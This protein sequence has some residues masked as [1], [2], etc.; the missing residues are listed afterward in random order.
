MALRLSFCIVAALLIAGCTRQ[1]VDPKPQNAPAFVAWT[2]EIPPY[3]YGPGDK[4]Q[5]SYQLTPE[6][7]EPALVSPDGTISLRTARHIKAEGLT[8]TELEAAIAKAATAVLIKPVVTVALTDSASASIYVGGAVT[9]PGAFPAKGRIGLLEA[10]TMAGG[11]DREARFDKVILVRR[12]PDN[13][14]MLRTVD[15][16]T[17]LE[18]GSGSGGDVPMTAGDMVFVPRSEIGNAD[19]WVE[20]FITKFVPFDRSFSYSITNNINPTAVAAP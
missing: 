5:V 20:E 17:F 3:R 14:P 10:V 7:D 6:M 18:K 12:S 16:Q 8:E 1:T 11:F 4:L 19:L 2:D 13:H 9:K 15:L